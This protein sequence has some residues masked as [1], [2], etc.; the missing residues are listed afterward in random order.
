MHDLEPATTVALDA[1]RLE[2]PSTTG[3]LAAA[4]AETQEQRR[5]RA[6]GELEGTFGEGVDR[7]VVVEPV[8]EAAESEDDIDWCATEFAIRMA[9]QSVR[10]LLP[11]PMTRGIGASSR[12]RCE[13][14]PGAESVTGLE[15]NPHRTMRRREA[16][17]SIR[18]RR[19]S[20]AGRRGHRSVS[21]TSVRFAPTNATHQT[22]R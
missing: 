16:R 1:R 9:G 13:C 2:V 5:F 15:V 19:G 11:L 20:I 4:W 10:G 21:D 14:D 3:A 18:E 8:T 22:S 7:I 17:R 12:A 6:V